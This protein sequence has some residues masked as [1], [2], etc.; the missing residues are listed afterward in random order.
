[1]KPYDSKDYL[2]KELKIKD[3]IQI[4]KENKVS[5]K[6]IQRKMTKFGLTKKTC[7]WTKNEIELLKKEYEMNS[8]IYDLFSNRSKSSINH[9]ANR[10]GLNRIEMCGKYK[11][12]SNFFKKWSSSSAYLLGWFFSDG[13][14]SKKPKTF[15]FHINSKDMEILIQFKKI[16]KS[17]HPIK[18]YG[19]SIQFRIGNKLMY[20]DLIKFGCIPNKSSRIKFPKIPDKFLRHFIRGILMGMVVYQSIVQIQLR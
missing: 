16:L 1:M 10:L 5:K 18:K 15:G 7:Y 11:I 9:K 20:T 4:A 14:I 2:L 13:Y 19:N 12:N 6:T 3:Y 8:K 17:T